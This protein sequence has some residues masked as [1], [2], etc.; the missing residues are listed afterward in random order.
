MAHWNF[1]ATRLP[2]HIFNIYMCTH[3]YRH[4]QICEY[5]YICIY[6]YSGMF[7]VAIM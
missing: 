3:R 5:V 7:S 4:A 1:L 2:T 6:I